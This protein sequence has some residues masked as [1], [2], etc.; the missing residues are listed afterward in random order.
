MSSAFCTCKYEVQDNAERE[1]NGGG[2]GAHRR[3][4]RQRS[5]S[6]E[7]ETKN[8]FFASSECARSLARPI[9]VSPSLGLSLLPLICHMISTNGDGCFGSSDSVSVVG[10]SAT[11]SILLP[12]RDSLSNARSA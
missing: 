5:Q 3:L 6:N 8:G 9:S 10:V 7:H 1:G 12:P 11:I 2:I 4:V